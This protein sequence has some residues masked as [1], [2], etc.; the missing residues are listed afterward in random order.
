MVAARRNNDAASLARGVEG[1]K[2]GA[3]RRPGSYRTL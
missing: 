3:L 2:P 1:V